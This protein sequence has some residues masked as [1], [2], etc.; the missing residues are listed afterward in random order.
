MEVR[1]SRE[2]GR[3][4]CSPAVIEDVDGFP[5]TRGEYHLVSYA[6]GDVGALGNDHVAFKQLCYVLPV[7]VAVSHVLHVSLDIGAADMLGQEPVGPVNMADDSLIE[8]GIVPSSAYRSG[9]IDLLHSQSSCSSFL[10]S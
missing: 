6:E 10:Q 4:S 5:E 2:H 7:D 8:C 1:I 3:E 9:K